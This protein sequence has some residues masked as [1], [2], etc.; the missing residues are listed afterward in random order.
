MTPTTSSE[1]PAH[2]ESLPSDVPAGRRPFRW[3]DIVLAFSVANLCFIQSWSGLLFERVFG[4]YNRVPVNRASLG[5]LLINIV[6]TGLILWLLVQCVRAINRRSIWAVANL[7]LCV[8]LLVPLN[9]ARTYFW[10]VTGGKVSALVKHPLTIGVAVIALAGVVWLHRYAGKLAMAVYLILSPMILFTVGKSAW[11]LI[12]PPPAFE[13]ALAP[14]TP[15]RTTAPRVVWLL[16]DEL[17]QRIAFE[18]IPPNVAL[19]ELTRFYNESFHATNAFPPGGATR[20]SLPALT[21]GRQVRGERPKSAGELSFKG[22]I[23]WSEADTVFSRARS[24]GFSTA[25]VGWYHPY[26]RVL[27]GHLERCEWFSYPPFEEER[28]FTLREAAINQLCSV[29]SQFQQRRLHFKNFKASEAAALDFLT[30]SP[31]GLTLLHLPVPHT[32]GIYDPQRRQFTTWKY[33]RSRE[34]LDNLVLADQLFGKIRRAMEQ[35]GTWDGTWLILSSDHWWRDSGGYDGKVDHRIPFIVKAPGQNEPVVYNAKF[36]TVITYH[37]ILS[38]LKGE[39]T[40]TAQLP[41]WMD[42]FRT[43]PPAG[44]TQMGEPF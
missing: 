30:N 18:T 5:A 39:L 44:Y 33:S 4:Y 37:L 40:S 7:A 26:G 3:G 17:D 9:F 43:E 1:T 10:E 22:G 36:D 16:L 29:F 6:G 31:A 21:M 28:G 11:L 41:R 42:A 14:A 27:G 2:V 12:N 19:P 13:D 32:P 38:I 20:Y 25:L 35:T 15:S 24:L 34:Y 8:A 23:H